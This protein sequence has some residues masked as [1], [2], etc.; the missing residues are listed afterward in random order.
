MSKDSK[1]PQTLS[2]D[3]IV[4]SPKVSRRTLLAGAGV[5]LGAAAVAGRSRSALASDSDKKSDSD[6]S[7]DKSSKDKGDKSK[8]ETGRDSD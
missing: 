2:D 7:S 6:K 4:T 5:A 3:D 8:I 1:V